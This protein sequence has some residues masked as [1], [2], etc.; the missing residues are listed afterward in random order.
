[1]S[2]KQTARIQKF[3]ESVNRDIRRELWTASAFIS[4][5]ED[6]DDSPVRFVGAQYLRIG[7][8]AMCNATALA[9]EVLAVGGD[10][11]MGTKNRAV[12]RCTTRQQIRNV[13]RASRHYLCRWRSAQRL[14]LFRLAEIF[15]EIT[16]NQQHQVEQILLLASEGGVTYPSCLRQCHA[17]LAG[18]KRNNE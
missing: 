17:G 4:Q 3:L 6:L 15:R 12:P 1:M 18:P 13:A 9:A 16:Q 14:G 8:A 11:P 7:A 10:P 2:I 5:A